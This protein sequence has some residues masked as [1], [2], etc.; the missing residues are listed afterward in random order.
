MNEERDRLK[1]ALASRY[2]IEAELG[3]GGMA[4]VYR[5][6]DLRHGRHVAI[7][8]LRP[9][10]ASAVGPDRFLREIRI[11]ANLSHP[12]ILPLL[13]SGQEDGLLFY[14]MPYVSGGSLRGLMGAASRLELE[15]IIRT[16]QQVAAALDYAHRNGVIHRDVKPENILLSEGQA[17]VADFGIAKAVSAA[18]PETLTRTGIPLGTPGYMSPEQAMGNADLDERTDIYSLACVVYELLVGQTPA[19]WPSGEDV[20][21]GRLF[22]A[23]PAHR[24]LLDA[25]PGRVEQALTKALALRPADRFTT[26][27]EF[28]DAL[29]AAAQDRVQLDDRQVRRILG[30]AAELQALNPTQEPALSVGAIEQI[31]A[32]VG[33]PPEHVR[34]AMLELGRASGRAGPSELSRTPALARRSGN[35]LLVARVIDGEVDESFYQVAVEEIET[36]LGLAGH[37]ST[38]GKSLSWKAARRGGEA[39]RL[40]VTIGLA[41]G[42]TRLRIE[43]RL[44]LRGWKSGAP[45]WGAVGGGLFGLLLALA[46]NTP[47][48]FLFIP[49]LVF[50]LWG[51]VLTAAGLYWS[52]AK[53]RLP[54]LEGLAERLVALARKAA[55]PAIEPGSRE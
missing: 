6:L 41:R 23:P 34:R 3:H 36:S 46:Q 22:D 28:A 11:T 53:A 32:E 26:A 5:A 52:D 40:E 16:V 25:L 47:E 31:A 49:A 12:H 1:R 24:Q 55:R 50:A 7:K 29:A 44:Q 35:K 51:G 38:S 30:R 45:G 18:G 2:A 10:L 13:D 54:R 4:T 19:I 8:V 48:P 21:L 20:R 17:V 42:R 27:L 14:A 9:E 33:I 37:A 15:F 39:H 43:E